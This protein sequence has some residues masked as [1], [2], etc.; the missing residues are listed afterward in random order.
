MDQVIVIGAGIMGVALARHFLAAG[1]P[2]ALIDPVEAARATAAEGIRDAPGFV[3]AFSVEA[4][5]NN[6]QRCGFVFEAVP[7]RLDQARSAGRAVA[8]FRP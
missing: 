5:E 2:V 4:L 8:A 7:E 1:H 6:W 3:L